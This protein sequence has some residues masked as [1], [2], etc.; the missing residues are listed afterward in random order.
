VQEVSGAEGGF[1]PGQGNGLQAE[2]DPCR[3][4]GLGSPGNIVPQMTE[5]AKGHP[6]ELDGFWLL[7]MVYPLTLWPR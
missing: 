2:Q 1:S 7:E 6:V 5:I 3:S 4:E